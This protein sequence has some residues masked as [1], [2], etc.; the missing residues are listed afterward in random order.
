MI[1]RFGPLPRE[2]KAFFNGLRL[3]W[4]AIELGFD[5]IILKKNKLRCY[6]VNNPQSPYYESKTFQNILKTVSAHGHKSGITLKQSKNFLILVKENVASLTNAEKIL[7]SL[8]ENVSIP[9]VSK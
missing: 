3:R 5:R 4:L 7:T 2:V 8:K 6:F 9:T 1:D